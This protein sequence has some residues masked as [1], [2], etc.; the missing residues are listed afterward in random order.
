MPEQEITKKRPTESLVDVSR[1]RAKKPHKRR[2][3]SLVDVRRYLSA[4]INDARTGEIDPTLAGRLA[5]MLNILK[6]VISDSDLETRLEKLEE[7]V[8]KK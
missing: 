2:L 8:N 5:Y 7:E 4:L 6:S 3:K 1:N